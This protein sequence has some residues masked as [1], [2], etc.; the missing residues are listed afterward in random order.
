[1]LASFPPP[2]PLS[3]S[4]PGFDDVLPGAVTP[5]STLSLTH[6]LPEDTAADG[7]R[8][9]VTVTCRNPAGRS[10]RA[11][12]DGLTLVKD[13]PSALAAAVHV[14]VISETQ[15]GAWDGYQSQQGGLR[16]SWEG[17]QDP[18]GIHHYEVRTAGCSAPSCLVGRLPLGRTS[19]LNTNLSTLVPKTN[20]R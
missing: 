8:L 11:A 5:Q 7:R 10:A 4:Q 19:H 1:M 16:A 13:P 12:S 9:F 2:P 17:F 20:D 14:K 6:S 18:F 15:Y 3:G